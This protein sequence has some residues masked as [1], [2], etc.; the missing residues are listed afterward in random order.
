[1]LRDFVA[2]ILHGYTSVI[3]HI[4]T[5][6]NLLC[7]EQYA[8]LESKLQVVNVNKKWFCSLCVITTV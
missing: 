8:N 4:N 2:H 1:M 5:F 6:D 3:Y 7:R